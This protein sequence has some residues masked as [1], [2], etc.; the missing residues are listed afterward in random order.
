MLSIR[1]NLCQRLPEKLMISQRISENLTIL[2]TREL[3]FS[4][5]GKISFNAPTP[6]GW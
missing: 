1:D 3:L 5:P 6:L 2:D 4:P